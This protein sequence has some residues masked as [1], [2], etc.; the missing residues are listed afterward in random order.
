[1][2]NTLKIVLLFF[3]MVTIASANVKEKHTLTFGLLPFMSP[4]ALFNRFAPLRDYLSEQ[5]G[6]EVVLTTAPSFEVFQQRSKSGEYDFVYTAPHFVLETVKTGEYDLMTT[7]LIKLAAHVLVKTDSPYKSISDLA[8]KKVAHAPIKAFIPIVGRYLFT[9]KGLVGDTSPEF[10]AFK[11]HNAAYRSV[12]VDEADAAIVGTY[13]LKHAS[14][15]GLREIASSDKYPGVA[16]LISKHLPKTLQLDTQNAVADMNK[17]EK[18]QAVLKL[19]KFPGFRKVSLDE[20]K[21]L[22]VIN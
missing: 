10:V 6:I 7:P 21:P 20:Y 22:A 18:G 5:L 11:S 2:K 19:I 17:D 9:A 4:V 8:N 14:R 1:M 12:L 13:L 3:C 15:L 16:I